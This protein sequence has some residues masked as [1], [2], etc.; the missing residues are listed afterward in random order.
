MNGHFNYEV[1]FFYFLQK[2]YEIKGKVA[3][4][5]YSFSEMS[6]SFIRKNAAGQSVVAHNHDENAALP[7]FICN[8]R[9]LTRCDELADRIAD[10]GELFFIFGHDIALV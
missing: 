3:T 10:A 9:N 2:S 4:I 7:G 5:P 8:T 1:T 6:Q